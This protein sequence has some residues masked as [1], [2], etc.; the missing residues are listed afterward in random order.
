MNERSI[1]IR[2]KKSQKRSRVQGAKPAR[3]VRKKNRQRTRRVP[4]T[5]QKFRLSDCSDTYLKA[6]TNP[7]DPTIQSACIPDLIDLP[8]FKVRNTLRTTMYAGTASVGFCAVSP[9]AC[10]V[11]DVIAATVSSTLYAD[12]DVGSTADAGVSGVFM[13]QAPFTNAQLN[14]GPTLKQARVV[15]V[16]VRARYIGKELDRAGRLVLYRA[17]YMGQQVVGATISDLLGVRTTITRPMTRS[18]HSVAYLPSRAGDYDFITSV[19]SA[20]N[21]CPLV[22]F[23]DGMTPGTACEIEITAHVEYIGTTTGLTRSHT[24]LPGLSAVKD[25]ILSEMIVEEPGPA[26]YSRAIEW[27]QSNGVVEASGPMLGRVVEGTVKKMVG[28]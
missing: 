17:S 21:V 27:I 16:G 15:G 25:V 18:W 20:N 22:I 28:L 19:S 13:G 11:N 1:V 6:L 26:W 9:T 10:L 24:D 12:I 14:G 5:Q 2:T 23:G 8:S 7:F 4:R 3:R